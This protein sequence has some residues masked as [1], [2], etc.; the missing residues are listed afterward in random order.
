MRTNSVW[1]A[2]ALVLGASLVG[3]G[4]VADV[5][6]AAI[7]ETFSIGSKAMPA[8]E[9]SVTEVGPRQYVFRHKLSKDSAVVV[10]S[11]PLGGQS[12][13]TRIVLR[14]YAGTLRIA[15]IWGLDGGSARPRTAEE[16]LMDEERDG[17]IVM[18]PLKALK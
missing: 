12:H 4:A 14:R 2:S 15:E 7:P 17:A 1:L 11:V 5:Y 18:V 9:Y 6:T 13:S 16:R 10:A 8:G 3:W